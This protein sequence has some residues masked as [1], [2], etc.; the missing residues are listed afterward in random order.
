MQA[1][2]ITLWG[3]FAV[4]LPAL[5]ACTK[6]R[7][8]EFEDDTISEEILSIVD[9]SKSRP[10]VTLGNPD[11]NGDK[12]VSKVEMAPSNLKALIK[13]MSF[14]GHSGDQ[15]ALAFEITPTHL[16]IKQNVENPQIV[17][18]RERSLI[19]INGK[20]MWLKRYAVTIK[21][22]G[23]IENIKN[24]LNEKT[25]KLKI[26]STDFS[27][28]THILVDTL[29]HNIQHAGFKANQNELYRELFLA[30]DLNNKIHN[31]QEIENKLQIK[32]DLNDKDESV[33]VVVTPNADRQSSEVEILFYTLRDKTNIKDQSILNQIGNNIDTK[34]V[35][36]CP[37]GLKTIENCILVLERAIT[38]QNVNVKQLQDTQGRS[39]P[40][41]EIESIASI[42]PGVLHLFRGALPTPVGPEAF[43]RFS[44]L[45]TLRLS[46]IQDKE[47]LFRRTFEDISS[48]AQSFGPG[49]SGKMEIVK[50]DL[51]DHRLVV[52]RADTI[53]NSQV[54]RQVDREELMSLPARYYRTTNDAG[55]PLVTPELTT[56]EKADFAQVDWRMNTLHSLSSPLNVYQ[57]GQC[58]SAAGDTQVVDMDQRLSTDGSLN[59]SFASSYS[60][61]PRCMSFFNV[62]DYW[63]N[64]LAQSNFMIKE[65][66]SFKVHDKKRDLI[67]NLDIP[68]WAQHQIGFGMFTQG[69]LTS[70]YTKIPNRIGSQES[71]PVIHDFTNG[72]TVTYHLGGL[73]GTEGEAKES[74]IAV[75]KKVIAD[76]NASLHMAFKGTPL[77]R[78]S[79]EP[80][81]ILKIDGVDATRGNLGDLDRNYIWNFGQSQ[82]SGLLGMAQPAPN[83]RTGITEAS[84]VLMYSGNV[85]SQINFYKYL[86]KQIDNYRKLEA[87][88]LT[89]AQEGKLNI[90]GQSQSHSVFGMRFREIPAGEQTQF[91]PA[92]LDVGQ[93][94]ARLAKSQ[95]NQK[96]LAIKS[97]V[98]A[99][100]L[101]PLVNGKKEQ[102]LKALPP[103]TTWLAR[104]VKDTTK[105]GA[106]L[107]EESMILAAG[108]AILDSG[109]SITA[110]E[111]AEIARGLKK[112]SLQKGLI[113]NFKSNPGCAKFAQTIPNLTQTSL[114]ELPTIEIFKNWYANTLSH[115]IGH[116]LGLTH[117]FMGSIDKA[118][119]NFS[120]EKDTR[121]YS[122]VMDYHS[123]DTEN[124]RGPGP[125]DVF[126]IRAGY[127][128]LLEAS[129]PGP[130]V[131]IE[132]ITQA[133]PRRELP[134]GE[135]T[136][137]LWDLQASLLQKIPIKRYAFCTDIHAGMHPMCNRWDKGTTPAEVVNHYVQAYKEGYISLN[138]KGD[139]LRPL[140]LGTY[141]GVTS[142]RLFEIRNFVDETFYWFIMGSPQTAA[143]YV[144]AAIKAYTTLMN[145]VNTPTTQ[146]DTF[147]I[148]RFLPVKYQVEETTLSAQ[149][150]PQVVKKEK[151]GVVEARPISNIYNGGVVESIRTR[152]YEFDK[153]LGTI[154]LTQSDIGHP[155]YQS[156]GLNLSLAHFEKFLLGMEAKNSLLLNH[157]SRHFVNQDI[158]T[159]FMPDG[160]L[161]VLNTS[162]KSALTHTYSI[163]ASQILLHTDT[164]N[165]DINF[166][167]LFQVGTAMRLAP[168]DRPLIGAVPEA[169]KSQGALKF[170]TP[171]H[172]HITTGVINAAKDLELIMQ[173]SK[174]LS[175]EFKAYMDLI[176]IGTARLVEFNNPTIEESRHL[177]LGATNEIDTLKQIEAT[178][179]EH[180]GKMQEDK[181]KILAQFNKITSL[182]LASGLLELPNGPTPI[183]LENARS[184]S[185]QTVNFIIQ[186]LKQLGNIEKQLLAQGVPLEQW[187]QRYA[188]PL[189]AQGLTQSV[190][191]LKQ[192]PSLLIG[193][194]AIH[195]TVAD[196][197][198][199]KFI[200]ENVLA[201]SQHVQQELSG[202]LANLQAAARL[203]QML[204]PELTQ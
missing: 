59:F 76:W 203:S 123:P 114:L 11:Q 26:R 75:T 173:V 34:E 193:L 174:Q 155:R 5:V 24:D 191:Q 25:H 199:L 165:S 37:S 118:N 68:V 200:A 108:Q 78:K 166:A 88:A 157:L 52:R 168:S 101:H 121:N 106:H 109:I 38:A 28:A 169:S 151:I 82:E 171:D 62:S 70:N 4:L 158:S 18:F 56:K 135:K 63:I 127:T 148:E 152:G 188:E 182:L 189:Q 86:S 102:A 13:N 196:S 129:R 61:D 20:E 107:D 80:Y 204:N 105:S 55:T 142:S 138:H 178:Q 187:S 100:N 2:K 202:I 22:L 184:I 144:P 192:D 134:N 49:S 195:A 33:Y 96:A 119:F 116:A 198:S 140:D 8:Q 139:R 17:D 51:E 66:V 126:A 44:T 47:F 112:A 175:H 15:V 16:F 179:A 190:A 201:N 92:P 132:A 104:F 1:K 97:H 79:G 164:L 64:G 181:Q 7:P 120:T 150:K 141:I 147:S 50:F 122:S 136:R 94:L 117:N 111:Q 69:R 83:P 197:P 87:Q 23:I 161:A 74:I 36:A 131:P 32:L 71:N 89:L 146:A 12:K 143:A 65:R 40:G 133:L 45:N 29:S 57:M 145:I 172:A 103:A 162:G 180:D 98:N 125:Y 21:S 113:A 73:D 153:V 77:E 35:R 163:L 95:I 60:F 149:G 54:A 10:I 72:R 27:Q 6:P 99:Q 53:N 154:F 170:W 176:G 93:D 128:G 31:T 3:I 115:E 185:M 137:S 58:F 46:D 186:T 91:L 160:G 42:K 110:E 130:L 85:M 81:L 14:F 39:T 9:L 67:K 43:K 30:E 48:T 156:I 19:E 41:I 194:E 90:Q 159:Y 84:N 177:S 124:Y 167:S 183:A